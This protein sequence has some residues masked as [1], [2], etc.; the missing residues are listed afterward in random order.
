MLTLRWWGWGVGWA[1]W[2]RFEGGPDCRWGCAPESL[3]MAPALAPPAWPARRRPGWRTPRT[4]PPPDPGLAAAQRDHLLCGGVQRGQSH[5]G[6]RRRAR[7]KV[8]GGAA[9]GG[10]GG[11]RGAKIACSRGRDG[12]SQAAVSSPARASLAP[13]SPAVHARRQ[14]QNHGRR[15]HRARWAARGG[16]G[17]IRMECCLGAALPGPRAWQERGG[18]NGLVSPLID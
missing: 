16:R 4:P 3:L 5:Q 7:A 18:A 10:G 2:S 6:A 15:R 14:G 17:Q 1:G 13:P 11:A 8:Q 12:S 9:G